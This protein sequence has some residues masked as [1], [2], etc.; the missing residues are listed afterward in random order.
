MPAYWDQLLT[1]F[2]LQD[3]KPK[4]TPYPPGLVLSKEQ[5]P[6]MEEDW[7]FMRDKP[8]RELLGGIQFGQGA[9]RPD[10]AYETN[11]LSQ[12]CQD[13]GVAHWHALIH[14]CRYIVGTKHLGIVFRRLKEG[15][16][17]MT[18]GDTN[19]AAC[20]DTRRSVSG[21]LTMLAGGPVF[22]MSKR[23]DVVSISTTES[24]YIA[25]GKGAQQA[26]WI[27]NFLSEIGYPPALPSDLY[28]D[29]KSAIAILENP[30]FHQRIKH[31][32]I[33][34]HFLRDLVEQGEIKIH[35]IPSEENLADILTKP[36]GTTLHRKM[37][38]MGMENNNER[39]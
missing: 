34:Y 26:K 25:Y 18:Y 30:R 21:V 28:A 19:H 33:W 14:L 37:G 1:K 12:F 6:K 39:N 11:D 31:I 10:M 7:H 23:Q 29:N 3:L 24:E 22:W 4:P 16:K 27:H 36:L 32:D 35:Y 17:P 5:S 15:L 20:I 8:Y 13:P 38:M 9:C 2:G